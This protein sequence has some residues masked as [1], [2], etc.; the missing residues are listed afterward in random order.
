MGRGFAD[1][2]DAPD[3]CILLF[4]VSEEIVR[5]D[6]RHITFNEQTSLADIAQAA[7]LVSLHKS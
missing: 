6:I 3:D 2:L 4:R 5:R 1:D 7:D